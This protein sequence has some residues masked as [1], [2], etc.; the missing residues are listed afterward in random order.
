M[1]KIGVIVG[2]CCFVVLAGIAGL[3]VLLFVEG[4][5][6][7]YAWRPSAAAPALATEHPRV[8]IDESHHNA[9]TA[10]PFGR[11][12]PFARL[13]EADGYSVK[14]G[15]SHFT[16]QR[17][18]DVDVLVVANASGAARLQF[19]GANLPIG[20]QGDRGAPAFSAAEIQAVRAWVERGGSLL[21]I[22]DHAPFGA[23][24]AEL[25]DAF[26]VTMG[27]GGVEVPDATSDPLAF[28]GDALGDHPILAG[29]DR[30]LTFTGQSLAGPPDA[31]ILLRLP[32]TAI[33]YV[34]VSRDEAAG[35][36]TFEDQPA[37]PAQALALN[38]GAGRVV[39]LGEAAML[40]AQVSA[41]RPFGLSTPGGDNERFARNLMRWLAHDD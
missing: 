17:L 11:Y 4:Q 14:R 10:G 36:T 29:V 37:G 33:E 27:E 21:L 1:R 20:K 31:T 16:Q 15:H 18:A 9:S 19:W 30:V 41:G 5:R 13:L 35:T 12:M 25:A 6:P 22:A 28:E 38:Y 7:D 26:G 2:V 24:S 23:A 40:T 34:E 8:L 3:A 32:P 39:V